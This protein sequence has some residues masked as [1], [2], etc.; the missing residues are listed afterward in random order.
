M[1]QGRIKACAGISENRLFE[2]LKLALNVSTAIERHLF[3]F[4]IQM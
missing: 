1:F 3:Q 2:R 4:H